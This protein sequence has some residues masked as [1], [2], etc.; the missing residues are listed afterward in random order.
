MRKHVLYIK[1]NYENLRD[2]KDLLEKVKE[3]HQIDYQIITSNMLSETEIETILDQIRKASQRAQVRVSSSGGGMLPISRSKKLNVNQIPILLVMDQERPWHI[4]PNEKGGK[5]QKFEISF[6][7]EKL[8]ESDQIE[9]FE[10]LAL[11]EED[12]DRILANFPSMIE[13]GLKYESREVEVEGG[14]IDMVFIDSK[15]NHM[16]VEIEIK[17]TDAAI[18]QVSRFSIPYAKKFGIP[19]EKIRKAIVCIEIS[20]SRI[21]ACKENNIEV[22]QFGIKS[23]V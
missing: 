16:L 9:G 2:I 13:K 4:F 19:H 23:R 18:G 3:K 6:Y 14:V 21:V 7:L 15:E 11:S 12:I 8:L 5:G 10:Q 1:E 22:Y 20:E 17:G